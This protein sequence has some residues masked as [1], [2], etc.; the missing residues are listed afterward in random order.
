M[1]ENHSNFLTKSKFGKMVERT[2]ID[3]KMSYM[4]AIVHLCGENNMEMED[5]AKFINP[6]IKE[7]IEAEAQR[8]NYLPKPNTLFS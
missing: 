6:V 2:V 1:L 5:I 4:D 3:Q 7:K 8:L